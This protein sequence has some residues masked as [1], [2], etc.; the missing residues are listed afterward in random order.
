MARN[1]IYLENVIAL[2]GGNPEM[3]RLMFFLIQESLKLLKHDQEDTSFCV[4]VDSAWQETAK[5]NLVLRWAT[6]SL[7]HVGLPAA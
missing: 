5:R 1:C 6:V 3:K 7:Q 4:S 2:L